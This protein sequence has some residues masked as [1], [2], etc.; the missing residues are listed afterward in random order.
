MN[1]T[2]HLA[3]TPWEKSEGTCT[4]CGRTSKTIWGD[5][6]QDNTALAVYFVQWTVGS[7]DHNP[8]FD[9]VLGPWGEGTLAENRVLVSLLFK[10]AADGGAFMVIDAEERLKA[11]R[12]ICGRAMLR[13]EVVGTRFADEVFRLVDALWLTDPRMSEVQALNNGI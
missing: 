6:S 13:C 5:L 9:F 10:P 3:A 7:S 2:S 8:N 4:C 1:E 12:S 11:K